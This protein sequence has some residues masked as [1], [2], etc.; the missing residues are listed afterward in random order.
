LVV[1][2]NVRI[3]ILMGVT[4]S[5]KTTIGRLL[6][7]DCNWPFYE[8]DDFHP[9]ANVEKMRRGMPLADEDRAPWLAA[10]NDRIR[11]LIAQPQ[12]AVIAC[13]ALK[14]AYRDRLAGNRDEVVFV[15]LKGDY[16]LARARLLSRKDHFMKAD[17]L[18]SQFD[19]LEEPEGVLTIDIAQEPDVIVGRIRQ[20]LG[21]SRP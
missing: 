8:G 20:T 15:Y 9:T 3:V 18:A 1:P 5:G 10:L 4:G 19:T 11:D 14:Q 7:K 13:S 21:L 17:L 12:S 16:D 6:A 2:H